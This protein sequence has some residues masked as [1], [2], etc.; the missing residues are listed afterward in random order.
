MSGVSSGLINA[1][2]WDD[3]ENIYYSGSDVYLVFN[4]ETHNWSKVYW[5]IPSNSYIYGS[6]VFKV[7][8]KIIY[9]KSGYDWVFD[10]AN[11]RLTEIKHNGFGSGTYDGF[12]G[13][14]IWE[15]D[16]ELYYSAGSSKQ[17]ILDKETN[18]WVSYTWNGFSNFYGSC[19]WNDGERYYFS[20]NSNQYVLDEE[21]NTWVEMVWNGEFNPLTSYEAYKYIWTDGNY[22]Y[23][24]YYSDQYI[25]D[26]ETYTWVKKEWNGLTSFSGYY[27]FFD[28][29][30]A[31]LTGNKCYML[32]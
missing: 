13:S 26:K 6:C 24:S 10:I 14:Y 18:T 22:I 1:N 31:Y 29:L 11:R 21:T 32:S 12:I 20:E 16:G 28:G 4:K 19:I 25:L 17:Y 2:I 9:F 7:D 5:S 30:N 23:Y 15:K 8:D 3:G 27:I